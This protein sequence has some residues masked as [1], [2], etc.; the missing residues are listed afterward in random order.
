MT[1]TPKQSKFCQLFIECGN[2]T[3]A[4]R[5]AGYGPRMSDKTRNEAASRLLAN[6]KIKAR[7]NELRA[8]HEARHDDN[9]DTLMD[10]LE[11]AREIAMTNEQ[12]AAAVSAI[13]GKSKLLGL[14][15]GPQKFNFKIPEIVDDDSALTV[16]AALVEG[17]TTGKLTATQAK[18]ISD[19]LETY[20]K[21]SDTI[22]LRRGWLEV[23]EAVK[24]VSR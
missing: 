4:H 24:R 21:L 14:D 23:A 11:A 17:L 3:D 22:E 10:Q 20:R 16:G 7:L 2:A 1:L 8:A 12:P 13:M 19:A 5:L 9:V 18:A 15:S 6:S